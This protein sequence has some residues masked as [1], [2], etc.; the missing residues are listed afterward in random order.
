MSTQKRER[1][2]SP[3]DGSERKRSRSRS[4]RPQNRKVTSRRCIVSNIPYDLKWQEVKDLFRN[5]VGDVTYV[6]LFE[7][8][9]GKPRGMG[10]VEFRDIETASHA[11]D[12]MHRYEIKDRKLVVREERD[13]DRREYEMSRGGGGG[14]SGMDGRGGGPGVMGPA[15]RNM[16]GMGGGGANQGVSPQIL[17]QLGIEGPLSCTVF[18][19]N[20]DYKVSW[21][22]LKDVFRLAGNVTRAEIKLDKNGK[23]RG[24]G[25]VSFEA[26]VEA[27]QAI[28]MFNNQTLFDRIMRVKLDGQ[29][30]AGK[31]EP[32]P[33]GLKSLGPSLNNLQQMS[34]PMDMG[35]GMG[36][37][38]M[39]NMGPGAMGSGSMGMDRMGSSGMGGMGAMGGMGSSMGTTGMGAGMG[40]MGSGM[41]NMGSNMSGMGSMGGSMGT[42][43]A[44]LGMGMGDSFSGGMSGMNSTGM[45]SMGSS[46]MSDTF[47]MSTM[48]SA[49]GTSSGFS[50][51]MDSSRSP[52]MS[53]YGSQGMSSRMDFG[54][55]T[56]RNNTASL[57]S[58]G[59]DMK[60]RADNT[61][62]IVKN[63][64][65]SVDWQTLKSKFQPVG[66][67]RFAEISKNDKG[68]SNGWGLVSFR[69]EE[70]A[71]VA[72]QRMNRAS[73]EGRDIVV[74]LLS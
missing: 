11:I 16:G 47:G 20:L 28:S 53:G 55:D 2:R 51:M 62:V 35:M 64:P 34:S 52:G 25:T 24:F 37:S 58:S 67:I 46:G 70:D 40:T 17:Q 43:G 27:V 10:V 61:T 15:P 71:K 49:M 42:M 21:K 63:L 59:S 57:P 31:N 68:K 66:D 74:K 56:S 4:P 44:G 72:V 3:L 22:K 60:T 69:R 19:S 13:R 30:P 12:K 39:G 8:P 7:N 41:G 36:S 1:S 54:R 38:G 5:E 6:E 65:Y 48:G 73:I 33:S 14:G 26:P 45:G 9:D 29:A 50:N 18:V 32:L 23:S